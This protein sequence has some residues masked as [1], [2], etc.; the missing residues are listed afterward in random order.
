MRAHSQ[1]PQEVEDKLDY[2]LSLFR[3]IQG[4]DI[5]EGFYKLYLS[6]RLLL[7]K[8]SNIDMEN[9][10][11]LRLK[12]ECGALFTSKLEGM[13]QDIDLSKQINAGFMD[14]KFSVNELEFDVRVLTAAHWNT[15]SEF[16]IILPTMV[17]L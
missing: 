17:I 5:F 7:G 13:F 8:S 6:K 1:D 12:E 15:V 14:S 2:G 16:S 11:L 4:K 9:R 3:S 10:M